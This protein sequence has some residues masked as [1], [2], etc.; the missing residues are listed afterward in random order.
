MSS[1]YLSP[2]PQNL[3]SPE[4]IRSYLYQLARDMNVA[5]ETMQ[6][7]TL[8][9]AGA[10]EQTVMNRANQAKAEELA[11]EAAG[12][13]S[14]IIKNA[15]EVRH[16]LD[17][18]IETFEESYVAIS[19]FGDYQEELLLT[20]ET[21]A[22]GIVQSYNYA[23]SLEGLSEENERLRNYKT[24]TQGYIKTGLLYQ[25][26][27]GTMRLGVAIGNNIRRVYVGPKDENGNPME[28]ESEQN[29]VIER[30]NLLATYT[31]DRINFWL[32]GKI[33]AYYANDGLYV[34]SGTFLSHVV[35]G[36]YIINGLGG[37]EI[38]FVGGD[39]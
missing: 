39:D 7:E 12:L 14:L 9:A 19:D 29:T 8:Q 23:S 31:D 4:A 27:D 17:Q 30:E 36:D 16:E 21:T 18:M 10:E 11:Q 35:I 34:L 22:R 2:P 15:R 3:N 1:V 37:F 26:E 32:N 28:E 6:A 33:V 25:D 5:L 20:I 13:K 24:E 38:D